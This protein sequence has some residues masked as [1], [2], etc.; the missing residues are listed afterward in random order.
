MVDIQFPDSLLDVYE[1]AKTT[2]EHNSNGRTVHLYYNKAAAV[3]TAFLNY[4]NVMSSGGDIE[5][6]KCLLVE[7]LNKFVSWVGQQVS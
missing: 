7:T 6:A 3:S 2:Y 4:T 5:R 1:R